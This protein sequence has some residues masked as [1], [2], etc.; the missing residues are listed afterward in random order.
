MCTLV[1]IGFLSLEIVRVLNNI[2]EVMVKDVNILLSE[3]LHQIWNRNPP[4][5]KPPPQKLEAGKKGFREPNKEVS[6][7]I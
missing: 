4:E 3:V 7:R 5:V 1:Q 2:P 6:L